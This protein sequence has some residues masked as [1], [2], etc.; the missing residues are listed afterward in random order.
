MTDHIVDLGGQVALVTGGGRGLGRAFAQALA[1]AGAS[2]V[3]T[4]R[5][6]DQ[7]AETV[8][9]IDEAGGKAIAVQGDVSSSEDTNAVVQEAVSQFGPVDILVNN[10]GVGGPGKSLLEDSPE[11][12]WETFEINVRGPYLYTRAVMPAMMERRQGR[13]INVSSGA[14][15]FQFPY[16]TAYGSSKAALSYISNNLAFEL[17]EFGVAIFALSPGLVRTAMSERTSYSSESNEYIRNMFTKRFAEGD[18]TPIAR[19]V[20]LF[21]FLASGK[22]D[23]LSGRAISVS[24]NEAELM[25]RTDEILERDLYTMRLRT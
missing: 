10:A 15:Y 3:V 2:V 4:A 22:A 24:D 6:E 1:E 17:K 23:A 11:E 20:E 13:I 9:L 18:D 5:S 8:K 25:E 21:M 12:W 19:T 7:I 14:A 16:Y